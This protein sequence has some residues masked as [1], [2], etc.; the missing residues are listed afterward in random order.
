M[1][2]SRRVCSVTVLWVGLALAGCV[3]SERAP[4]YASWDQ[5]RVTGYATELVGAVDR[6]K[7]SLST[8]PA[9]LSQIQQR[10]HYELVEDVRLLRN[11]SAH[12]EH[13]LKSGSGRDRT[14]PIYRRIDSLR[15]DAEEN[16]RRALIPSDT[17]DSLWSVGAK[18][19]KLTRYYTPE[20]G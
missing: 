10:A 3:T 16:A 13:S 8:E 14:L 6:L 5:A 11:T 2:T 15:R 12:L 17:M 9:I 19:F 1:R 18:L 20:E 4:T 7:R